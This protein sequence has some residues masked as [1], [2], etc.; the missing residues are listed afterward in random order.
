MPFSLVLILEPIPA[1]RA[2]ELLFGL[3]KSGFVSNGHDWAKSIDLL[4]FFLGLKLFGLLGTAF[5]HIRP[6]QLGGH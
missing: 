4:E 1:K 5:A 3:M 2:L 6:L